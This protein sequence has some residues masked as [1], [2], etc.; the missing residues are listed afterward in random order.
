MTAASGRLHLSCEHTAPAVTG[1]E[2][3]LPHTRRPGAVD[4]LMRCARPGRAH[5]RV[6]RPPAG[7]SGRLSLCGR[8]PLAFLDAR[9]TARPG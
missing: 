3:I 4:S 2:G 9:P 5:V 6:P 1:A 7:A 8:G